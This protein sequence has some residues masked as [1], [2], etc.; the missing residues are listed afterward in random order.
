MMCACLPDSAWG[1]ACRYLSFSR[2]LDAAGEQMRESRE[3]ALEKS[4]EEIT[5]RLRRRRIRADLPPTRFEAGDH[6]GEVLLLLPTRARFRLLVEVRAAAALTQ[7]FGLCRADFEALELHYPHLSAALTGFI[8]E[9]LEDA[10]NEWVSSNESPV[11]PIA[12]PSKNRY[13]PPEGT[14]N[15]VRKQASCN[16]NLSADAASRVP[17]YSRDISRGFSREWDLFAP[18]QVILPCAIDVHIRMPWRNATARFH[19]SFFFGAH[20]DVKSV[21]IS[22]EKV[23]E[24]NGDEN[25]DNWSVLRSGSATAPVSAS[26]GIMPVGQASAQ[27]RVGPR[28]GV[29]SRAGSRAGSRSSS[30]PGSRA[31][32]RSS[33]AK[34]SRGAMGHSK[35]RSASEM[36]LDSLSEAEPADVSFLAPPGSDAKKK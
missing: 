30:A 19:P 3:K 6:I 26:S 24:G 31:G 10:C 33:S 7:A 2:A 34:R 25:G 27:L 13:E 14:H 1:T 11:V 21:G 32:S 8:S 5:K 20:Q 28:R 12:R 29:E 9:D 15:M 4:Q 17:G 36:V 16:S 18:P 23:D 22:L 35:E